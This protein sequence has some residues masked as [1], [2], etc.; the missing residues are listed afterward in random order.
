M[1]ELDGWF[2]SISSPCI[3]LYIRTLH[4]SPYKIVPYVEN[5]SL[6]VTNCIFD[7]RLVSYLITEQV[8]FFWH[9]C[10]KL[11]I[12]FLTICYKIAFFV[13]ST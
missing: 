9:L 5:D 6:V 3:N 1:G 10:T 11:K 2:D 4:K 12:L 8:T 13:L 7:L